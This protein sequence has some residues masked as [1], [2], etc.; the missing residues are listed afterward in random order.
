MPTFDEVKYGGLGFVDLTKLTG[1]KVAAIEGYISREFDDPVFQPY[2]IIFE[3]GT[4]VFVEGE[5]DHPYISVPRTD[6][7]A[8]LDDE[9]LVKLHQEMSPEWYE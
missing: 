7:P 8:N 2:R 3:D 9:T 1:V 6:P 5:H 4:Q